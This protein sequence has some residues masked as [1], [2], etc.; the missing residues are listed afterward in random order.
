MRSY[1]TEIPFYTFFIE[2]LNSFLSKK[3]KYHKT[4]LE[5]YGMYATK[6]LYIF[7]YELLNYFNLKKKNEE[8]LKETEN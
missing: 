8:L 1:N 4:Q 2:L 3:S 5:A 6:E 7:N